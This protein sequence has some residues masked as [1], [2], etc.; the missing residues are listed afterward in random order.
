MRALSSLPFDD[1]LLHLLMTF[2]PTFADMQAMTLVSKAFYRVYQTHPKS[3][4]TAVAY[5][6]VGPAFPQALRVVRYPYPVDRS[7]RDEQ[8]EEPLATACSEGDMACASV[9]TLK[10]ERQLYRNVVVVRM[11]EDSYSLT[12]KDRTSKRSVLAWDESFRFRRAVYRIMFY[13]KLFN[14]DV[15]DREEDVQLVRRQRTAV[16]SQYSTDELLQLYAVVQFMRGICEEVCDQ[17][18]ISDGMVDLMLS[19]GPQGIS[20]VWEDQAYERL[21]ELDYD[22]LF[23]DEQDRL[24]DGYFS[25]ALDSIWAARG[26][27]APKDDDD[28]PAS[29]WILDTVVGAKDTCSQCSTPGGL[30]LLTQANWHRIHF[31]P[32]RFLKGELRHN[33]TISKRFQAVEY[34]EKHEHGPWISKIFDFASTNTHETKESEWAGWTSDRSYCPPCLFKFMEE[35]VWQ[36]FRA[37]WSKDGWVPPQEDCPYGYDCKTMAGDEGHAVEKNHLCVPKTSGAQT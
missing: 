7:A 24:Y 6:L 31:R 8:G 14:G 11:L 2:C 13:C 37:Q 1:D 28:S 10:E 23:E 3:I 27:E 30:K 20:W 16:L 29:R 33:T 25:R 9:I 19:A 22:R 15:D 18:D 12:Q 36:W 32:N 34:M 17:N 4:N 21:D 26:V 5:N 35:Y